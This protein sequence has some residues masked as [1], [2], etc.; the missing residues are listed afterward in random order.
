MKEQLLAEIENELPPV[1]TRD[2]LCSKLGGLRSR[3][4]F[5]NLD[6]KN[7]GIKGRVRLGRSTAYLRSSVLEWLEEHLEIINDD[8]V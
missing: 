6:V 8:E 1:V 3:R 2:Y 5:E 7:Q 4:T